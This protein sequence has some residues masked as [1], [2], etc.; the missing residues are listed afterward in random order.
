MKKNYSIKH[1]TNKN[2][3]TQ[4]VNMP[5]SSLEQNEFLAQGIIRKTILPKDCFILIMNRKV[6][7]RGVINGD[8]ISCYTLEI[9]EQSIANDFI[10]FNN[11]NYP[12]FTSQSI[13]INNSNG[14][15]R[16]IIS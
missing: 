2:E 5:S 7:G 6:L 15:M 11:I 4:M 10:F 16:Y 9:I 14:D 3:I 13:R 12:F 8:F 1:P